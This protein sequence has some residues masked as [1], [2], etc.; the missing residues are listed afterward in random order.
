MSPEKK[1]IAFFPHADL[2]AII[3]ITN[4]SRVCLLAV[5]A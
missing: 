4:L 1:I 2:I 5:F 3:Q